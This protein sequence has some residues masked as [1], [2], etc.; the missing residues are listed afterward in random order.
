MTHKNYPDFFFLVN[1]FVDYAIV[2]LAYTIQVKL[3][4]ELFAALRIRIR[5]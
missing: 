2:T 3:A 1:N 5:G 4:R